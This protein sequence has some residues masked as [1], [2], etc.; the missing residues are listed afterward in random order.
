MKKV[1]L[2]PLPVFLLAACSVTPAQAPFKAGDVF[3]MTGTTTDKKAVAHTYTLRNDGQ[4]DSQDDE[5]NYL[6]NGTSS[7]S[8]SLKINR[9]QDILYTTD[10]QEND[11]LDK[12]IYTACFAQTDGPGWRTAEGFLVQGNLQAFRD[13]TKRMAGVPEGQLFKT[14]KSL[15]G[16]CVITRK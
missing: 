4:W 13:F 16:E 11:D 15:S 2:L 5:W 12:Q 7:R 9:E 6:A 14:F 8:A 1:L 3:E 10:T